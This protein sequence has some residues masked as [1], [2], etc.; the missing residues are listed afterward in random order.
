MSG[1]FWLW[2]SESGIALASLPIQPESSDPDVPEHCDYIW[3]PDGRQIAGCYDRESDDDYP[4]ALWDARTG[5]VLS[6]LYGHTSPV[7]DITYSHDARRIASG[8]KW[9]GTIR[10]W[11]AESG[12]PVT[13][14]R[15]YKYDGGLEFIAGGQRIVSETED[16]LGESGLTRVWDVE[17]GAPLAVYHEDDVDI[18]AQPERTVDRL[19][20]GGGRGSRVG[21]RD[22]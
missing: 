15:G 22:R 19:R 17:T 21:R 9:D 7:T 2:D 14:L 6:V 18:D 20:V 8:S 3:S 16:E 10:V 12:A 1:K 4:I 5:A 13:V 11:D